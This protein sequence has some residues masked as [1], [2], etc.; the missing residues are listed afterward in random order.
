MAVEPSFNG[1]LH[2]LPKDL[3]VKVF[4]PAELAILQLGVGG[5]NGSRTRSVEIRF[6]K[7]I[8]LPP[9]RGPASTTQFRL[10]IGDEIPGFDSLLPFTTF[11]SATLTMEDDGNTKFPKTVDD[12]GNLIVPAPRLTANYDVTMF[13]FGVGVGVGDIAKAYKNIAASQKALGTAVPG[14]FTRIVDETA[15]VNNEIP[16]TIA[17]QIKQALFDTVKDLLKSE[18]EGIASIELDTD[19]SDPVFFT[20]VPYSLDDLKEFWIVALEGSFA[21]PMLSHNFSVAFTVG[22]ALLPMVPFVDFSV[23]LNV[24]VSTSVAEAELKIIKLTQIP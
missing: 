13:S 15:I 6:S 22:F 7:V 18:L 5:I 17:K 21:V 24:G 1:K 4:K 23:S 11:S 9:G 19:T 3:C 2:L 12:N 10:N 16:A 14:I 8:T 20:E